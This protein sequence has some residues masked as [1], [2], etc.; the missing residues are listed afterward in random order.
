MNYYRKSSP[1]NQSLKQQLSSAIKTVHFILKIRFDRRDFS[2]DPLEM[3]SVEAPLDRPSIFTWPQDDQ[4]SGHKVSMV[5]SDR[6]GLIG[7]SI[8][9]GIV[10]KLSRIGGTLSHGLT[11][12]TAI[13]IGLDAPLASAMCLAYFRHARPILCLR[14]ASRCS[15]SLSLLLNSAPLLT[16]PAIVSRLSRCQDLVRLRAQLDDQGKNQAS[17]ITTDGSLNDATRPRS[18]PSFLSGIT[19]PIELPDKSSGS[20]DQREIVSFRMI[21]FRGSFTLYRKHSAPL[22]TGQKTNARRRGTIRLREAI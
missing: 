22:A 17:L 13:P 4:E 21:R 20:L 3:Y 15:V 12:S 10:V 6:T 7:S 9:R 1:G 14:G 19:N 11:R 5:G 8:S 16:F 18:T 2:M